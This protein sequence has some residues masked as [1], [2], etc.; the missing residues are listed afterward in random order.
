MSAYTDEKP[1]S[2]DLVAA[3]L[4]QAPFTDKL[5]HLGWLSSEFFDTGEYERVSHHCI[6]R[7]QQ[8]EGVH[9]FILYRTLTVYQVLITDRFASR[10]VFRPGHRYRFRLAVS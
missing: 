3:V 1:F 10:F 8:W 6:F 2:V 9:A 5:Y 4:R 7:Y